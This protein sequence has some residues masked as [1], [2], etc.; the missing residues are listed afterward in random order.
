M[1]AADRAQIFLSEKSAIV[2]FEGESALQFQWKRHDLITLIKNLSRK[3]LMKGRDKGMIV[4]ENT[5][6]LISPDADICHIVL[7]NIS[8]IVCE[9]RNYIKSGADN[10]TVFL[11]ETNLLIRADGYLGIISFEKVHYSPSM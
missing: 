9:I 3:S 7:A 8:T 6:F 1:I 11:S 4:R 10:T 5:P 2:R